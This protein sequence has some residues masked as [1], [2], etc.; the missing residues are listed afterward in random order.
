[1]NRDGERINTDTEAEGDLGPLLR[2]STSSHTES[3]MYEEHDMDPPNCDYGP[4][5]PNS[6][7]LRRHSLLSTQVMAQ[8]LI[9]LTAS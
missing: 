1:M 4:V 6:L 3:A 8:Q 2:K 9:P 5:V 7:W